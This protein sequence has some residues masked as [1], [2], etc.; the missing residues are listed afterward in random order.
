MHLEA[1][2]DLPEFSLPADSTSG[3]PYVIFAEQR[4]E[5]YIRQISASFGD[6]FTNSPPQLLNFREYVDSISKLGRGLMKVIRT[7][8]SLMSHEAYP[9]FIETLKEVSTLLTS[10]PGAFFFIKPTDAFYRCKFD[11]VSTALKLKSYFFHTPFELRTKVEA[12]RFAQ[13]AFPVLYLTNA[14]ICGFLETRATDL[15]GFQ[16]VK[17]QPKRRYTFLDLDYNKPPGWLRHTNPEEYDLQLQIK[18]LL[19]PLLLCCYSQKN[20][21]AAA[22]QEYIIPQLLLRWVKDKGS[23]LAGIK[24]PSTRIS[25][26]HYDGS[27]YNLILP[28][29]EIQDFGFCESLKEM[30]KMTEV[31]GHVQAEPAITAF[32]GANFSP[33]AHVNT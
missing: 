25:G 21:P 22:P 3:D 9:E 33:P 29:L 8:G 18:G 13:A 19:Y 7:N 6:L 15:T 32:Y 2:L 20:S 10:Y 27:F 31:C 16:A 23:F 17:F 4:I 1:I 14:L 28:P 12:T 24:Y 5:S 11:N 26:P 30:F